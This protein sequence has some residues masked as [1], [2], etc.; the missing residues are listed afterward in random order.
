MN[1]PCQTIGNVG[2]KRLDRRGVGGEDLVKYLGKLAAVGVKRGLSGEKLVENYADRI[3]VTSK[4]D[5]AWRSCLLGRHVER[6]SKGRVGAGHVSAALLDLADAKVD[7]FDE[8]GLPLFFDHEA[9]GGLDVAMDDARGMGGLEPSKRL[10][11]EVHRASNLEPWTT[12]SQQNVREVAPG[13]KLHDK[14]RRP[15]RQPP[16][17]IHL[18]NVVA[19]DLR[20]RDPLVDKPLHCPWKR[21]DRRAHELER[22]GSASQKMGG[23]GDGSH[24]SFAQN[25]LD[26]VLAIE[27]LPFEG[28]RR[29]RLVFRQ[30]HGSHRWQSVSTLGS[31]RRCA[32]Q[33]NA[34]RRVIGCPRAANL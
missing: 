7:Q 25:S 21:H 12:I 2:A 34:E 6:S 1:G 22:N 3:K 9:V 4:V 24:S 18:D 13:Q 5:I 16:H 30:G 29:R 11:R 23:L 28:V 14:K 33:R 26:L 20:G 32:H 15:G 27:H 10:Q 8:V 19:V 17:V 31:L